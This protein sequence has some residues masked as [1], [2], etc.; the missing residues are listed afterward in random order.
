MKTPI[1]RS[2]IVKIGRKAVHSGWKEAINQPENLSEKTC[3]AIS[4]YQSI[5]IP[6]VSP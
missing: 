3:T 5:S 2:A 6:P 4:L 1:H